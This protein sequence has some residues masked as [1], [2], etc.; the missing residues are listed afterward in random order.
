LVVTMTKDPEA[1]TLSAG[2]PRTEG[3]S[4]QWRTVGAVRS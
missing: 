4:G 2:Q 3:A 1:D